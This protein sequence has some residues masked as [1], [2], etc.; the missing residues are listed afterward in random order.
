MLV[1][2]IIYNSSVSINLKFWLI[3]SSHLEFVLV[4]WHMSLCQ[5]LLHQ[6]AR[7]MAPGLRCYLRSVSDHFK[8]TDAPVWGVW[9]MGPVTLEQWWEERPK[10]TNRRNRWFSGHKFI[11]LKRERERGGILKIRRAENLTRRWQWCQTVHTASWPR[12]RCKAEVILGLNKHFQLILASIVFQF[13]ALICSFVAMVASL[14]FLTGCAAALNNI[15]HLS[16]GLNGGN[17]LSGRKLLT[18]RGVSRT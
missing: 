7:K 17:F 9:E 15:W 8:V 11:H 3:H 18:A 14:S 12:H 2:L 16:R 4:W 13:H 6:G 5:L 10:K 1:L